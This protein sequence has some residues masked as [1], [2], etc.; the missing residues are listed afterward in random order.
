M[1]DF[2]E[3]LRRTHLAL[4]SVSAGLILA[5]S[6]APSFS[7]EEADEQVTLLTNVANELRRSEWV[8]FDLPI[9]TIGASRTTSST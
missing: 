2:V 9:H 1:K 3:H 7:L 6:V 8:A 5:A 4:T